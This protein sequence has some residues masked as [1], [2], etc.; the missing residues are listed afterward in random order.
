MGAGSSFEF[1]RN[2]G[3]SQSMGRAHNEF[4]TYS[5]DLGMF[6]LISLL[7][8]LKLIH[9]FTSNQG[10][11][12][13]YT[14]LIQ[15]FTDNILTYYFNYLLPLILCLLTENDIHLIKKDSINFSKKD[16]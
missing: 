8:V 6:G 11:I 14:I 15:M 7:C 13:F 4:L 12:I 3:I 10:K 16:N 1:L 9:S 5:Y 2:F